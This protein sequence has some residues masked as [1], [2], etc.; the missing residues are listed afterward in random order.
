MLRRLIAGV[1]LIAAFASL[2]LVD[3]LPGSVLA[4][5][6]NQSASLSFAHDV[7]SSG[8]VVGEAIDFS[9]DKHTVWAILDYPYASPGANLSYILRL[10]GDD[11]S[12]GKLKCGSSCSQVAI[13]LRN[14]DHSGKTIPGG[15]YLLLVYDGD[16]E[17][18]RGG[19]G[20]NGGK[21]S[22]NDNDH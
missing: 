1:A 14:K 18:A 3:R 12:W 22:D 7:T 13:P 9:R 11:Y 8:E 4:S 6:A 5:P 16:T 21:G 2:S 20:V 10:N 19:F 17:I 15:A